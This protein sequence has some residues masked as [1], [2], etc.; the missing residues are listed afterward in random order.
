[1]SW[2]SSPKEPKEV[3]GNRRVSNLSK[4]F[5][6]GNEYEVV[7]ILRYSSKSPLMSSSGLKDLVSPSIIFLRSSEINF[8]FVAFGLSCPN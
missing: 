3:K 1:M 7:I 4:Y 2:V 5:G 6:G 8:F